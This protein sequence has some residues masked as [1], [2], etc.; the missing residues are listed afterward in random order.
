LNRIISSR[1]INKGN[2]ETFFHSRR[3]RLQDLRDI[4][5]RADK[6]DVVAAHALKLDHYF[7]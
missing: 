7:S 1:V 6:I 2:R 5:S 4:M 3:D